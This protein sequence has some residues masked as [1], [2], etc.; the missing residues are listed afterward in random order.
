MLVSKLK[1][2]WRNNCFATKEKLEIKNELKGKLFVNA[3]AIVS[4]RFSQKYFA[5]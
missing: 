1:T 4:T 2:G 3:I 5:P